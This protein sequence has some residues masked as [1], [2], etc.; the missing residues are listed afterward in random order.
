MPLAE[1]IPKVDSLAGYGEE[2]ANG[3]GGLKPP[4]GFKYLFGKL[5]VT[6][7]HN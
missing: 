5:N 6:F 3:L 2:A 7:V 1:L 4:S